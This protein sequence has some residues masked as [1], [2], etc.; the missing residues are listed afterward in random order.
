MSISM[1][2]FIKL[3][4]EQIGRLFGMSPEEVRA[5]KERI[6]KKL[7]KTTDHK[8]SCG[9]KCRC[10][11]DDSIDIRPRTII[12]SPPATIIIWKNGD[13]T[14]VKC[15]EKDTYDKEKGIALCYMKRIHGN[16][17]RYYDIIKQF[18]KEEEEIPVEKPT[19][20]PEVKKSR[21]KK[22]KVTE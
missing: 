15:S 22:A 1:S 5:T 2:D 3:S 13:K 10:S 19:P 14:V 8:C 9:E 11:G 6:S 16:S 4:D 21:Y 7:N 20:E 18:T 17:S 12:F